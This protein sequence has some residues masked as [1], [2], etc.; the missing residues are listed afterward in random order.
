MNSAK[1]VSP[2]ITEL[3]RPSYALSDL[4]GSIESSIARALALTDLKVLIRETPE[5]SASDYG[6]NLS[7]LAGEMNLS[8]ELLA[9]DLS[10][11]I[12]EN[13][14]LFIKAADNAGAYLN[15]QVNMS[16]FG[17]KIVYEVL[18]A[19]KDYGSEN[20]AKGQKVIIDMSSPN[21]AKRM[22]YGHLRSTVIGDA[23]ANIYRSEGYEVIRDNHLGD[24]GTQFGNLIVAIKKWGN[25]PELLSSDDP[26]GAL[27]DLYVKFHSESENEE[28]I[29]R[30]N[31]RLQVKNQGI[32]SI[33]GLPEA[34]ETASQAIMK[35]KQ[36]PRENLDLEK[37][38]EDALDKVIESGLK[39]EGRSWFLKLEKGDAEARRLW[40]LCVDLSMKEFNAMYK[41]LG[42]GFEKELGESFYENM[43]PDVI[44]KVG[45]SPA[46]MRSEGALVIDMQD[47]GLG[48][49]IVQKSDG[50]S[51]YLTRDLACAIYREQ[52]LKAEKIV[53]VV[54]EDQKQY[55]QQ[56]FEA[57]RRLGYK[58]GDD[59]KHVYFGMVSLP[60]GKMSTR[61][62][63]V[64][65]LK[66]V[67]NEG[68]RKAD[69]I[70]TQKNP[71][72]SKNPDLKKEVTRQ[73]SIGALKWNDLKQDPKRSVV[74][75]WNKALNFDGN[76]APYVQYAA[77]RGK[78]ILEAAGVKENVKVLALA[79][80]D[81]DIF[82]ETSE[83]ALIKQ[84]SVYPHVLKEALENS[85]PA[86]VAT[87][88]FELAKRFNTFYMKTSVLKAANQEL[89]NSR[90]KLV[91]ATVQTL[92]NALGVLGIE[93]PEKM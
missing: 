74:F 73:I 91:A 80:N 24:W 25:E 42:V 71:E 93:V 14:T 57:L 27:Q 37:I 85:S 4:H 66:D 15:F 65:L 35:R 54:G 50:A 63:R 82:N 8:P 13:P 32:S 40:K 38:L 68:L 92:T 48:V 3:S 6:V 2:I 10:K 44:K 1:E 49:A 43:L 56:L 72:L 89:V 55:F 75:D 20:L 52:T 7:Q 58:I 31:A 36:I 61:K 16:E 59:A 23:L 9:A 29:L 30:G 78:S 64:I 12:S 33:P 87:Y 70:L 84:L 39:E 11:R 67:V 90:L 53:Y 17:K 69:E 41:I 22:S 34:F 19:G 62:G 5:D 79:T 86:S 28:K 51:L 81:N 21:I 76:S 45:E 88:A 47:K 46:G 26:I 77:V 18:T 83:K 60:E